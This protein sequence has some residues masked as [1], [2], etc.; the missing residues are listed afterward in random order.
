[1]IRPV[2]V[3]ACVGSLLLAIPAAAQTLPDGPGK[4]LVQTICTECHDPARI[5]AQQ[6]TKADWAAK[7][8]EMLQEAP[9]VTEAERATIVQY[10]AAQFPAAAK[11]NVNKAS[12]KDLESALQLAGKD[13]QAI[14]HYRE[15]K[16]DFRNIEDLKKVPGV[17][18]ARIEAA[19]ARLDF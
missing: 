15:E 19:K 13:A 6:K 9:D 10:L 8:T 17:D 3:L 16:G 14:V 4:E 5:V 7:V 18:A 1:M 11:I 2:G 12:A